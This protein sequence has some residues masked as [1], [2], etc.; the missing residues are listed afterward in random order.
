MERLFRESESRGLQALRSNS[1]KTKAHEIL[2]RLIGYE[3][4]LKKTAEVGSNDPPKFLK[5]RVFLESI[6]SQFS[7]NEILIKDHVYEESLCDD[8]E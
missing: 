4:L 5:E 3:G 8:E 6:E 1:G 7:L 2:T